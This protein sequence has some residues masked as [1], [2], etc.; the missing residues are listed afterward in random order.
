MHVVVAIDGEL[1]VRAGRGAWQRAAGVVT[2]PDV[3]H[4]IDARGVEVLL[5]FLDPESDAGAALRRA[6]DGA[7]RTIDPR[8]RAPLIEQRDPIAIMREDGAAWTARAAEALGASV[9]APRSIHPR[10][11]A[12]LRRLRAQPAGADVSLEALAAAVELSPGRLMHAFTASIGVPLRPYLAWLKLQRAAAGIVAGRPL[13]EVAHA[14][15]FSDSAHMSRTFRRM[16]GMPP[17]ALRRQP[18][19]P[20]D[21]SRAALG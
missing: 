2:A 1:R 7:I 19:D 12:V 20:S 17:S 16:F 10:V 11:R 9:D 8:E 5:V 15:G 14:A 21:G 4:A 18:V 13:T 3:P 6:I